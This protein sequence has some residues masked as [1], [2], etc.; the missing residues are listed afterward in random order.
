M[1]KHRNLANDFIII[2]DSSRSGTVVILCQEHEDYSDVLGFAGRSLGP[3]ET[4]YTEMEML[5]VVHAVRK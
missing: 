2:V 3:C 1:L 4:R 5:A